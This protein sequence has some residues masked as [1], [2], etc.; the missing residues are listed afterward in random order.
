MGWV[1][2][3]SLRNLVDFVVMEHESVLA[4]LLA[5]VDLLDRRSTSWLLEASALSVA[6]GEAV[7]QNHETLTQVRDAVRDSRRC[8]VRGALRVPAAPCRCRAPSAGDG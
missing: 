3:S 6:L 2:T 8:A 7:L 1:H 5:E 4:E